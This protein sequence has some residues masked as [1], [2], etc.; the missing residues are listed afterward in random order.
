MACHMKWMDAFVI[1]PLEVLLMS[2]KECC[3]LPL[4]SFVRHVA[5]IL[6]NPFIMRAI[7][8]SMIL[9]PKTCKGWQECSFA[10]FALC[11]AMNSGLEHFRKNMTAGEHAT[12][13]CGLRRAS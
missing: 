9:V 4:A 13:E 11:A 8:R 3:F 10:E 2:S 1:N 7:S 6:C 12:A 5:A